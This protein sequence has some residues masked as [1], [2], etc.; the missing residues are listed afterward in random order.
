MSV[1]IE[2]ALELVERFSRTKNYP[3]ESAGITYLAEGL[4]R[5]AEQIGV[6]PEAIVTRLSQVSEWCPTDAEFFST[7]R[8]IR[9]DKPERSNCLK[10]ICDGSGWRQVYHLRTKKGGSGYSFWESDPIDRA[11]Y[12]KLREQVD[13]VTQAVYESRFRCECHPP[14][15][16]RRTMHGRHA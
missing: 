10:G 14:S 9:G 2:Q 4:K 8:G 12:E 5:A 15:E 16:E 7:A 1:T 6:Q 3:R 11:Q 13:W